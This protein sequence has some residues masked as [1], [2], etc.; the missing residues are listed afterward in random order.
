MANER[1]P[2]PYPTEGPRDGVS[3]HEYFADHRAR[4]LHDRG[5]LDTGRGSD[6]PSVGDEP[7][8]LHVLDSGGWTERSDLQPSALRKLLKLLISHGFRWLGHY[9]VIFEEGGVYGEKA[10]KAGQKKP[11]RTVSLVQIVAV[12]PGYG[13]C[14]LAYEEVRGKWTC[15]WR[16]IDGKYEPVSDKQLREWINESN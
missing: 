8:L 6:D 11:D 5:L 14:R 9:T 7:E 3:W 12:K 4:R 13:W 2:V 16:Q 15:Y 1:T 10:Q